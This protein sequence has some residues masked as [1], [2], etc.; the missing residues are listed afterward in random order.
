MNSMLYGSPEGRLVIEELMRVPEL[1]PASGCLLRGMSFNRLI[2][3]GLTALCS[4]AAN[5]SFL[6]RYVACGGIPPSAVGQKEVSTC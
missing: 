3:Q 4:S 1:P 6:P 2:P 5:L